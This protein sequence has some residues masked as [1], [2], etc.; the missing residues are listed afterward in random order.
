LDNT[1][2]SLIIGITSSL[3]AT[4]IFIGGSLLIKNY[5]LPWY[6]DKIYTGIRI[7]GE[8]KSKEIEVN[9]KLLNM[10]KTPFTLNLKQNGGKIT[11]YYTHKDKEKEE[12]YILEG[13]IKD[14]YFLATA[15]PVS[16]RA[17]DG[18]S[19]LLHV[20]NKNSKLSMGGSILAQSDYG[21]VKSYEK[22]K[23]EWV[24]S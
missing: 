16:K 17:T 6:E 3:V 12:K 24:D 23:F 8:W 13:K 19:F 7:D 9:G 18:V 22:L 11:G 2:L 21:T 15:V 5:F 10:E 20:F 1:T 14:M 4:S